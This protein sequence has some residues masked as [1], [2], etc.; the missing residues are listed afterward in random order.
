[1]KFD[2]TKTK[3]GYKIL[4]LRGPDSRGEFVGAV[5]MDVCLV[6]CTWNKRGDNVGGCRELDLV[7]LTEESES[8]RNL[9]ELLDHTTRKAEANAQHLLDLQRRIQAMEKGWQAELLAQQGRIE[10]LEQDSQP[11]EA[12]VTLD[13][14]NEFAETIYNRVLLDEKLVSALIK[15]I[16]QEFD[17]LNQKE[18]ET[19]D[20]AVKVNGDLH[21]IFNRLLKLEKAAEPMCIIPVGIVTWDELRK[22]VFAAHQDVYSSHFEED[23]AQDIF[24]TIA[25]YLGVEKPI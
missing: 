4:S 8:D 24:E 5:K 19:N 18:K 12:D 7:P 17:T 9:A 25:K 13:E 2:T 20:W 3:G 16:E 21:E 22:A 6:G 10:A 1:M 14:V 15:D 11:N 23:I